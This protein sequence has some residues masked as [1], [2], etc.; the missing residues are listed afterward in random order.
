M[1]PLGWALTASII[2]IVTA[3]LRLGRAAGATNSRRVLFRLFI[4]VAIV[5]LI[6]NFLAW[7]GLYGI[8]MAPNVW[9]SGE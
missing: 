7:T 9:L 5:L 2:V 4:V 8:N 3:V 1:V 6:M